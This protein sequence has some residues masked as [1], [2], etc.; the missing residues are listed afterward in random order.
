MGDFYR[1]QHFQSK[2][3]HPL[4]RRHKSP[5]WKK[6]TRR[7]RERG[8]T[9]MKNLPSTALGYNHLLVFTTHQLSNGDIGTVKRVTGRSTS[10]INRIVHKFRRKV[11]NGSRFDRTISR[12]ARSAPKQEMVIE[13]VRKLRR[14]FDPTVIE[15]T[16]NFPQH[17]GKTTLYAAL[18]RGKLSVKNE[19]HVD[20]SNDASKSGL[21][22]DFSIRLVLSLE[23]GDNAH[24]FIDE[25]GFEAGISDRSRRVSEKGQVA[26]GPYKRR[27][28]RSPRLNTII[29]VDR[30]GIVSH[31]STWDTIDGKAFQDFFYQCL[32]DAHI[33]C[34][35]NLKIVFVFDQC[36]IHNNLD[37]V[38]ARFHRAN[39]TCTRQFEL[40]YTST[41]SPDLNVTEYV[42]ALIKAH[43]IQ[44]RPYIDEL[45]V[46]RPK[47]VGRGDTEEFDKNKYQGFV[48]IFLNLYKDG[49]FY[50]QNFPEGYFGNYFQ[51]VYR[52][53]KALIQENGHYM[54]GKKLLS[55]QS[56]AVPP[57]IISGRIWN[58]CT[59]SSTS[60]RNLMDVDRWTESPKG[61]QWFDTNL[62]Q[63]I[64]SRLQQL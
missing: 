63:Y 55:Q 34:Y 47:K 40:M 26:S 22:N 29:A 17:V 54:N 35:S 21:R 59:K 11:L 2:K 57:L 4:P 44:W 43:L 52:F 51:H 53:A 49:P 8:Y 36:S 6:R 10:Q 50:D 38:I 61:R 1:F 30:D 23:N 5:E 24:I 42:N 9:H 37:T 48:E 32:M 56:F 18:K 14:K 60:R 28:K 31:T 27:P 62:K 33:R 3:Q 58:W 20:Y 64:Q 15:V 39:P 13:T 19:D 45:Y 46:R 16:N 25:T 12:S 7:Q 41:H